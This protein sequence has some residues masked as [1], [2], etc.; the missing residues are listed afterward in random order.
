[1]V[2]QQ[3]SLWEQLL[4]PESRQEPIPL[5]AE[6]A[7]SSDSQTALR[8]RAEGRH[9]N[10]VEG[11]PEMVAKMKPQDA[12]LLVYELRL[13]Q[14]E[15]EMQNEDLRRAHGALDAV[16]ER[17]FDLYDMAPVGYCTVNE[18]GRIL[19]ANLT[20]ATMLGVT[21]SALVKRLFTHLIHIDHRSTYRH[22]CQQVH[23]SGQT[24]SC[25]LPMLC[26]DGASIWVNVS[27]NLANGTDGATGLRVTLK[28]VTERVRLD[29]ELKAQN[30]ELERTRLVAEKASRAKSD[31]LASM[32]HELRSPLN[33]ILGFAQLMETSTPAPTPAQKASIDQILYGGWH[34]LHLVNEILELAGIESG[35]MA[36][37]MAPVAL[38]DVLSDCETMIKPQAVTRGI[39]VNFPTFGQPCVVQGD[40][41]RLQQVMINLLSNAIKY[42]RQG[43]T[44]EV[45]WSLRPQGRVRISVRD[46]GF[47]LAAEQ[48][49]LLF[50]PFNRLGQ[51]LG[52]LE[53][54]GI[55]LVVSKRLLEM[56]GGTIGAHSTLG[57]G[58]IFWFEMAL[59]G[60]A[61]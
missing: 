35:Q 33:A 18:E 6:A 55:G 1:M 42:N 28:D 13:H 51:E 22:C 11:P 61:P 10:K 25:D 37:D 32:S 20:A 59:T 34:L 9:Q 40:R 21:R 53:G 54:T 49:D 4:K 19:E 7:I 46:S 29:A 57:Q 56:M 58:S 36:L 41:R 17:Y 26:G 14:V 16:R 47:G 8:Q 43:G 52:S 30:A 44:V 27:A 3:L 24:Q 38:A 39:Q 12:Q 31:F 15:L 2:R 23:A 45:G 5:A 60:A 48:L 50:Q